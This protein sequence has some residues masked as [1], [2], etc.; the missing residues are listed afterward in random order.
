MS[1]KIEW[2]DHTWNP[3]TGCS[4]I[5]PACDNCYAEVMAKRLQKI[6]T[7]A[8]K[9]K[10]GF[11]PTFHPSAL[12]KPKS[13]KNPCRIFVV[14]MG[15]IFHPANSF[16]DIAKVFEVIRNVDRHTYFLLTKRPE[17]IKPFINFYSYHTGDW[18]SLTNIWIG[19]TAENQTMAD[20]RIPLLLDAWPRRAFVSIEPMLGPIS[21]LNYIP[22][23]AGNRLYFHSSG[24]LD[25]VIVGG[26]TGRNARPMQPNWVKSIEYRCQQSHVPFFFK[27]WGSNSSHI[28]NEILNENVTRERHD[29]SRDIPAEIGLIL[30]PIINPATAR[31]QTRGSK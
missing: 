29:R 14:S 11:I 10:N 9:Y 23:L 1:T 31:L 26:E 28:S 19:V 13:W 5:S 8:E 18:V 3:F 30:K 15:D 6:P 7:T 2:T 4:K 24:N 17:R 27:K 25:W 20:K 21:L 12:D 16:E 22:A